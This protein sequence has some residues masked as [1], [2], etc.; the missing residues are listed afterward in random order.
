[1]ARRVTVKIELIYNETG[2]NFEGLLPDN[3]WA[4]EGDEFIEALENV[5]AED[6]RDYIYT[7]DLSDW[8][9]IEIEEVE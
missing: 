5:V 3:V 1:M 2:D 6:L 8:A 4:L 9:E 7:T